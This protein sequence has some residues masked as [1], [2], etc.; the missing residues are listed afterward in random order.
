MKTRARAQACARA[1]FGEHRDRKA[2]LG[3]TAGGVVSVILVLL[4]AVVGV[5]GCSEKP[6]ERAVGPARVVV[7][8]PALAGL[9][10]E[11]LPAGA[12]VDV[13]IPAG[14]SPHGFE[15][16]ASDL[17]KLRRA[18][19]VIL[20]GL[21][22]EAGL[23]EMLRTTDHAFREVI[24][25][26]AVVGIESGEDGDEHDHADEQDGQDPHLWL[27]P[28][29]AMKLVGRVGEWEL[30]D[31]D[32]AAVER[33]ERER[34]LRAMRT[35][36]QQVRIGEIEIAYMGRLLALRGR[37]VI[38]DHRAWDRLFNQ[39]G[40][41]VVGVIRPI[42]AVEPSAGVLAEIVETIKDSG[43]TAVFVE[44]QFAAGPADV[45]ARATGVP[46][47]RLDPLGNGDWFAMMEANL[48]EIV[49]TLE[50]GDAGD[51]GD[52]SAGDG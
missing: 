35:V 5:A 7:S 40:I 31:G 14:V 27:D 33:A 13:L 9:V 8:I 12:V 52:D 26:A 23:G 18:D 36:D 6:S 30:G 16:K 25:F 17:A 34:A 32:A 51:A 20:N 21:G 48:D 44:P 29:L 24:E 10:V 2:D 38:T 49:R 43:V 19:L 45:V 28:Q 37:R 50:A 39:Y 47:G 42:E 11:A 3:G 15:P 1:S 22:V 46:I 4:A 41:D